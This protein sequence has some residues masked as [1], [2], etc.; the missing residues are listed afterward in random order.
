[1][2]KPIYRYN[3]T[4]RDWVL[5]GVKNPRPGATIWIR[6]GDTLT[7]AMVPQP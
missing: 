6:P 2:T 1:M 7:T 3:W 5:V 4:V